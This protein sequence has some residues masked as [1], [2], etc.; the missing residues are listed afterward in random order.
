MVSVVETG[1]LVLRKGWYIPCTP[2]WRQSVTFKQSCMELL[3]DSVIM[4]DFFL[5]CRHLSGHGNVIIVRM[6]LS[7]QNYIL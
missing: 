2:A 1:L 3:N 5:K 4:I 6:N 7:R